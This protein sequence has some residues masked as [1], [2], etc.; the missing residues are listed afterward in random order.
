[1]ERLAEEERLELL[2]LAARRRRE[3]D[4]R[5]QV[6]AM[7]AENRRRRDQEIAQL[8]AEKR[9][10]EQLEQERLR[11]VEQERR[12][13][14]EQHAVKLVHFLPKGAHREGGRGGLRFC[15]SPYVIFNDVLL[16]FTIG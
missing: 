11:V 9:Q 1:M 14:L 12:R 10:L 8:C 6:E 16:C 13:L 5:R 2:T 15:R 7:M 4:H 3:L